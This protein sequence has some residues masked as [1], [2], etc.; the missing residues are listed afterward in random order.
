[1][2]TPAIAIALALCVALPAGAKPRF[3][4]TAVVFVIDRSGSMQGLR[5]D[6][7]KTAVK[8]ALEGMDADKDQAAVVTFDSEAD[9]RAPLTKVKDLDRKAIQAIVSGGGTNLLPG[10]KVAKEALAKVDAKTTHKHVV[11]LTDGEAP[12]EGIAELVDGMAK[13]G[14]TISAMGIGD[15]DRELLSV[16]S[17][18]GHGTLYMVAD[19]KSL[20]E[21]MAKDV[22]AARYASESD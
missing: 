2:R 22:V 8:G 4:P 6:T 11:L 1:V 16:I 7:A 20:P 18:H 13:D 14:I 21:V 9:V 3:E 15:A 10:L 19:V 17:K 5:L 12:S